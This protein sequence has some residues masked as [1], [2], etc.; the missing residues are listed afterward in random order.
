MSFFD[1]L[2]EKLSFLFVH[3][4]SALA[5]VIFLK[6][7]GISNSAVILN[8]LSWMVI[9]SICLV[10]NFQGIKKRQRAILR[11]LEGLDQKYLISDV[12][13]KPTTQWEKVYYT[14]LREGTK[15]M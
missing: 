13:G 9:L 14:L 6:L 11:L 12:M 10:V 1:Y 7:L 3:I 4:F 2:Y 15:S 8:M 5:L